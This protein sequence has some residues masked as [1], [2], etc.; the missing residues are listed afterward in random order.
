VLPHCR[1]NE[2]SCKLLVMN[3]PFPVQT[4]HPKHTESDNSD[5]LPGM[6]EPGPLSD[7]A[8]LERESRNYEEAVSVHGPLVPPAL[9]GRLL[10]VSSQAVHDLMERRKLTRLDIFGTPWIPIHEIHARLNSPREVGGRPQ[11]L[12]GG[13]PRKVAQVV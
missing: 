5:Y 3:H 4:S 12:R 8:T 2:T 7:R 10:N 11:S 9:G 13:R 6:P 1:P